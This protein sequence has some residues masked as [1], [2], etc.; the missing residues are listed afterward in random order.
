MKTTRTILLVSLLALALLASL[1]GAGKGQAQVILQSGARAD[2]LR[3]Q[4]ARPPV[5]RQPD[6]SWASDWTEIAPGETLTFTH[7]LGGD[8]DLYAVEL[9]FFDP[10]D[11]GYGINHM[12]YGGTEVDGQRSGAYWSHLS[13]TSIRVHRNLADLYA[14]RV[15]VRIWQ[16]DPPDWDSGWVDIWPGNTGIL[17]FT[18]ALGGASEDYLVGIKF[19]DVEAGGLGVHQFALGGMESNGVLLGAAWFNLTDETLQVLRYAGDEVADEVRLTINLPSSEPAYDS[20]WLPANLSQTLLFEH[21]LGGSVANYVVRPSFRSAQAPLGINAFG[22]GGVAF[23]SGG[24]TVYRGTALHNLNEHNLGI[25]RYPN[26]VYADEM[27]LRIWTPR[28]LYLPLTVKEFAPSLEISYDDG[29]A[30]SNQSNE[31]DSGFAVRFSTP[32]GPAVL[33]TVRIYLLQAANDHPIQIHVWDVDH[34]DLIP[35]RQFSPAAGEGWYDFDFSAQNLSVDGD[36]YIGFLY[37]GAE[38]FYD[39][40]IG[41]DSDAPLDGRSYEVP[42]MQVSSDYMIRVTLR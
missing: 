5:T 32:D 33:Q 34:N 20:G 30:D 22:I 7:S 27:R 35:A 42:W 39:P 2:A 19:R 12:A 41:V 29:E 13:G 37:A 14:D 4:R 11:G 36:F 1:S 23:N 25:L 3:P 9:W 17:T 8:S 26:D 40:S 28:M 15:R 38:A 18:H 10:Q 24:N 6:A 21:E 31:L 16:P